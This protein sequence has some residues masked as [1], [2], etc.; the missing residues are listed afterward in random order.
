MVLAGKG[1]GKDGGGGRKNGGRWNVAGEDD[2]MAGKVAGGGG[3][4]DR[5]VTFDSRDTSNTKTSVINFQ[6][7]FF[8]RSSELVDVAS[9]EYIEHS[10]ILR[11]LCLF[12]IVRR[13]WNPIDNTDNIYVDPSCSLIGKSFN[14][15]SFKYDVFLSFRGEDTRTNFVDHLY[16]AL[17]RQG[18][19]TY[20]DDKNLMKGNK[21]N[22]ELVRAIEESRFHIIVFSK[23]YASS[24]WCLDELV[25]IMDCQKTHT[26]QTAYPIFYDV[27]PTEVR[28]QTGAFGEAIANHENKVGAGKWREA[29]KEVADLA[30]WELKKT[31]NGHE[32]ELIKIVVKEILLR[33]PSMSVDENLVGMRTRI[34]DVVSSLNASPHEFQIIGIWGMGGSGKTTLARAVFDQISFQF[35]GKSFV[36]NVRE[37]S[38]PNFSGLMKLQQQILQDVSNDPGITVNNVFDG[39]NMMKKKMPGRKVLV[40]LDDVDHIEQLKS[41]AGEPSWF[42]LGSKVIITTRDKQVLLAHKVNSIHDVNLLTDEEAICLLSRCAFGKEIPIPGYEELSQN[43]VNYAAGLPLTITILGSFLCNANEDVWIDTLERL[44]K[45]PLEETLQKLELSYMHLN[46][47]CK[48]IFLDV[49]CLL[50]GWKEAN[51]IRALESCGF[52]AIR[53]LSVLEKKS[54]ITISGEDRY[55]DMHDHIEEMGRHIVRC[56]N[57]HEPGRH[58]RLWIEE[59]I[60]DILVNDLGT[61]ATCIDLF[62]TKVNHKTIMK[63]LRKMEK[64]RFLHV[65]DC[66]PSDTDQELDEDSQYLP[67]SLQYLKWETSFLFVLPKKF[68]ASNLVALEIPYSRMKKLWEGGER[69]VLN[70]LRFLDLSCSW[71]RTFDLGMTPN[72]EILSFENCRYL[73]EFHMPLR[74]PK[75]KSLNLNGSKLST[76][77]LR[78]IPN[79]ETL[80]LMQCSDLVKL[81]I[82]C[83][84]PQL[85]LLNASSPKL[86]SLDLRLVPNITTLNLNGCCDL[87]ELD[88]PCE[89]PQLTFLNLRS[90]KLRSIDL[91]MIPNIETLNLEECKDLVELYM[92]RE[93]PQL[94][95]LSLSCL[96][97]RSLNLNLGSSSIAT[98]K[99]E[100]RD[101][102]SI[103]DMFLECPQLK[104]LVLGISTLR[105]LDIGPIPNLETLNL[106]QCSNLVKLCMPGECCKLKTLRLG[107]P[108]LMTFDHGLTRNLEALTLDGHNDLVESLIPIGCPELKSFELINSKLTSLE[109]T[110]NLKALILKDC[111]LVELHMPIGCLELKS[112]DIRRCLEL[113]TLDLGRNPNLESLH[114]EECSGLV[115]LHAPIGGL[116]KLINL[117]AKGFLRFTNLDIVKSYRLLPMLDL[118]GKLVDTCP[119]HPDNN[120]PKFQFECSYQEDLPS[121][122]GNIEKLISVGFSCACTDLDSFFGSICGLQHL[123]DL[124]LKGEIPEVPKDLDRLQCLER[125]TLSSTSIK[126]LPDSILLL[127]YLKSLMLFDCI[128]LE[129]LPE[130]FEKLPEDLGRLECLKELTLQS[131]KIKHLPDSICML[132]HLKILRLF[133][134]ELLEKLPEDLG[135]LECLK[136]LTLQSKKIKH[137][138]DSICML[139]HLKSL[140]IYDCELLEKLPEDLGRLECLETVIL[141][142]CIGLRNIPNNICRLKSLKSFSLLR[143]NRVDKLP[144][145]LGR[146]ECLEELDIRGTC[147][148]N[149][150]QSILMIEGLQILQDETPTT[151]STGDCCVVL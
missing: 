33:L 144:D 26:Q 60:E 121:S 114:L 72:L 120:F 21:I 134:C 25:K 12:W 86:R 14:Q 8:I 17:K 122:I 29:L 69:K 61:E 91:R 88:I 141:E 138:P 106:Q 49:A 87:L 73:V 2:R 50:K 1:V 140:N 129:K 128:H 112:I 132:K 75:L 115:K 94:K 44:K 42:M 70:K 67:N 19:D 43:V 81:D 100:E 83:E 104:S 3:G 123:G 62:A 11:N 55:L 74:C 93:C 136:E 92:P 51:A 13:L 40:I 82:P 116:K 142:Q 85:K 32:V 97:L 46:V 133:D 113:K 118:H 109:L 76:L 59:E 78:L 23:N 103:F 137:L 151:A 57:P 5:L 28:K 135:R 79:I 9:Y 143:C 52:H 65:V 147:I 4:G 98:L 7:Q 84:F 90:S 16:D 95:S 110:L 64:L 22:K 107:C 145:Q 53:G 31:A 63:G 146:V 102:L 10:W 77:D 38:K 20:K 36:A 131:K 130:D 35:E 148:T 41:L 39:K 56:S 105:T 24:S 15:T 30:G 149:L 125:L 119:L 101:N 45:I 89:C 27:E 18:I 48:E 139:K 80:N 47:D 111:A 127:K 150:P 99:L 96:T 66:T 68:Q 108:H 71:L 6:L 54:L 34:N 58:N 126:H 117:K 37:V 124:R